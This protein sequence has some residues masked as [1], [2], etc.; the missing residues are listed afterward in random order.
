MNSIHNMR[1]LCLLFVMCF[2]VANSYGAAGKFNFVIGDVRV[3][4]ATGER[5]AVR[6]GEVEA[7]DTVV[8]GKGGMAQLRLTDGAFIALRA[9][10]VLRIDKYHYDSKKPESNDTVLSLAKG[11][12]RAF[13]GAIAS[14]NK[15]RFK[16]QTKTATVGIRGSG[17]VLNFSPA[18]NL[19]LNHTIEGSH[20][21]T[22]FDPSGAMRTLVTMPG[23]TVQINQAGTIKF[24][25][26]PAYILEAMTATRKSEPDP[27]KSQG[28][29]ETQT[30]ENSSSP[31]Q[32]SE[33][34]QQTK[35]EKASSG[36]ATGQQPDAGVTS[37][38]V[39][40]PRQGT[41][42]EGV[43]PSESSGLPSG[44]AEASGVGSGKVVAAKA[45][46]AGGARGR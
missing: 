27:I 9:D 10:T 36:Q 5:A 39:A 1:C 37:G 46:P 11:T 18:D 45:V 31:V 8:S 24:V 13:T 20:T 38:E 6:G 16:M 14:F 26:T 15:D 41:N 32:S 21:I 7:N 4:N 44:S 29:S 30:S 43:T 33:N 28:Q 23:Q 2:S 25:P 42:A 12:M 19:T 3:V 22:A 35:K 40:V 34:G 17:N